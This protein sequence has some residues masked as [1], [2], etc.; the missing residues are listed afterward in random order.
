MALDPEGLRTHG[1]DPLLAYSRNRR[2]AMDLRECTLGPMPPVDFINDFLPVD[3]RSKGT[4]LSYNKAFNAIPKEADKA[5]KIYNP[6]TRSLNKKTRFKSRCPGFVFKKTIERSIRPERLGHAKPHISCFSKDQLALVQRADR[7]SR[8]EFGYVEMF[9]QV[10]PDSLL[11]YFVDPD[12]TLETDAGA[13]HDFACEVDYYD[14]LYK[15]AERAFGL[16]IAFVTEAFARQQRSFMFTAAVSGSSARLFRWD[17]A[18]CVVSEAFDLHERPDIFAEFL[19][20]FSQLSHWERGHDRTVISATRAQERIFRDAIRDYVAL[21]L[22]ASGDALEKALL[23]HYQ[24]GHATILRVDPQP[25][26]GPKQAVREYIVSRPVVSPLQLD[27]RCTRGYWAVQLDTAEVV[28]LKDTWRSY[29]RS[30]KE[31]EG[32]ILA[33]LNNLEVR[34]VPSLAFHGDCLLSLIGIPINPD[35]P[36]YEDTRTNDYMNKAWVCPIDGKRVLVGKRRHYRLVM[37]TVGYSIRTVQGTE[38]LLHSTHDVLL[39]MNDAL[40]KDSRIHRDLSVGNIVLVKELGCRIRKGYLID[41]DASERV[42]EKGEALHPGRAGTWYF[43]SIRMLE[44]TGESE[45]SHTFQDDLE[46]LLYVVLYCGLLYL[47]HSLTESTL[48]ELY[49][50]F[51]EK[52]SSLM[53][54]TYGGDGKKMNAQGRLFT[55]SIDFGDPAFAEWLNTVMDYHSP[56]PELR[57][58]YAGYW[59]GDR[60]EEF[61]SRFL[62]THELER[63]NRTVHHLSMAHHWDR[64]SLPTHSSESTFSTSSA[65]EAARKHALSSESHVGPATQDG[66]ERKRRRRSNTAWTESSWPRPVSPVAPSASSR[67][68]TPPQPSTLPHPPTPPQ[69]PTVDGPIISAALRRSSRIREQEERLQ[70]RAFSAHTFTLSSLQQ[71]LS[72]RGDG[73]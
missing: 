7:E 26:D 28:F 61:W 49:V 54:N 36:K 71:R 16:H 41:W 51:F 64:H 40:A 67:P 20:R 15:H 52:A 63:S 37:G 1:L 13:K 69:P 68:R 46:A 44:P 56:P 8:T 65:R 50:A 62:E 14:E 47:P 66:R 12:P 4:M 5:D 6:L 73:P 60:L 59:N 39:A 35:E 2:L 10:N 58:T 57:E 42:N 45:D 23:V 53:G 9:I 29:S 55:R 11:D 18:G 72:R 17:R 48:A 31:V 30:H 32:D 24:P 70:L 19:W 25:S 38:E 21:Q 22:D 3:E 27:G 34:N 33:R 43:M